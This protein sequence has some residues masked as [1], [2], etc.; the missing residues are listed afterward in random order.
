[1][2]FYEDEWKKKIDVTID[3]N[4]KIRQV[5]ESEAEVSFFRND[6]TE[7]RGDELHVFSF[8]SPEAYSDT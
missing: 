3:G 6:L 7:E 2:G 1:M 4:Q 8:G 5:M